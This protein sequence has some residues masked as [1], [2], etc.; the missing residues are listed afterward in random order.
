MSNNNE[1][2][3]DPLSRLNRLANQGMGIDFGPAPDISVKQTFKTG[4][5][6][7]TEI[8]GKRVSFHPSH[9]I[10]VPNKS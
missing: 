3:T 4:K 8:N 1:K 7:S 5:V 2:Y 10:N 6:V 9:Q